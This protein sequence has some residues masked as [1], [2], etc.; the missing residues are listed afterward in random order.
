MKA[1]W[2][3]QIAAESER[4]AQECLHKLQYG[5]ELQDQIIYTERM[6]QEAYEDFMRE[7]KILDDVVQRIHEEDERYSL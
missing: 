6:K 7:K 3:K 1:V 4:E 2:E 5:A